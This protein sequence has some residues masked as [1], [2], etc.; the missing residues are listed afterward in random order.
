MRG[1][2][3]LGTVLAVA[4]ALAGGV[5][6]SAAE[7]LRRPPLLSER[8]APLEGYGAPEDRLAWPRM[9]SEVGV[10]SVG[11]VSAVNN[12]SGCFYPAAFETL[13]QL[14]RDFGATNA[15]TRAWAINQDRVFSACDGRASGVVPPLPPSGRGGP[16]RAS[17]DF[18]YQLGSWRFYQADYESALP[19]FRKVAVA[20]GVV[21][22]RANAAYMAMRT[23]AYLGR[24]DEAYAAI[25]DILADPRLR[26]VHR[27]AA[28]YRFVM[29]NE[30]SALSP[31]MQSPALATR[32]LRWLHDTLLAGTARAAE[33]LQA[34]ADVKDAREQLAGYFTRDDRD[35]V[36]WWLRD[37]APSSP[38]L[39]A[40]KDLAS[41]LPLIDWMQA[42]WAD[43]IFDVDWLWALHDRGNGYWKGNAAIVGHAW[44]R[45]QADRDGAWLQIAIQRVHPEDPTARDVL[46][47]AHRY[48]DRVQT[49]REAEAE[50]TEHAAWMFTL[51]E[52]ALRLHLGLDEPGE[53]IA[54]VA[55][56]P[57]GGGMS[58]WPL[59]SIQPQFYRAPNPA[60]AVSRAL[61]W[62]VYQG[63]V[64]EARDLLNV[65]RKAFP[66]HLRQWR[67]LLATSVDEAHTAGT[68]RDRFGSDDDLEAGDDR[69]GWI[70][71]LD[72]LPGETLYR[73]AQNR[74][75]ELRY[76]ALLA[77]TAL[78]RALILK[79]DSHIVDRDAALAAEL[80]PAGRESLL[81]GVAPHSE[82]AYVSLL[83]RMPRLRPAV[84]AEYAPLASGDPMEPAKATSLE[85]IDEENH[86]D[87]NWWCAYRQQDFR[88]R[89][90]EAWKIVPASGLRFST[91]TIGAEVEPHLPAQRAL[92]DAHPYRKLVDSNEIKALEAIPSAPEFLTRA[93]V[94]HENALIG[95]FFG[96]SRDARAADLHR[97][98]RSTR[99]G[100][101]R[102]GSHGDA[103]HAAFR[104]LQKRYGDSPWAKATPYWFNDP[105]GTRRFAAPR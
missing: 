44:R 48:L 65:A 25:D 33:P 4:A 88:S 104:L 53:A 31:R 75:L 81:A 34:A 37:E 90:F 6:A 97:A 52:N 79:A 11:P 2:W 32:H 82:S 38:R 49:Q 21:P 51:W 14:R 43:N 73:M 78:A 105:S 29:M 68:V 58:G 102:D 39:V 80:N 22:Q 85:A 62:L 24:V 76:R 5:R 100:C 96:A 66:R 3:R 67:T 17:G 41:Q 91:E 12:W 7:D 101:N 86:N 84:L 93:V 40:V 18:L 99:Y 30:T 13:R 63:K 74:T 20:T 87:D 89:A 35:N 50:S 23:L 46:A 92:L 98:V 70:R 45:W 59:R 15:Y 71:L 19:A 56:V 47:A 77:R 95:R 103:S 60:G 64:S 36:D 72:E 9:L 28:N 54:L 10:A 16:A 42:N 27:I 61:R 55:R 1:R 57:A 69:E 8:L 83:L 26:E 94:A